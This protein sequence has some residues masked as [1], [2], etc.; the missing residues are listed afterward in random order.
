M[1]PYCRGYRFP[2]Y[3]FISGVFFFKAH[4]FG[5]PG[6]PLCC[7]EGSSEMDPKEF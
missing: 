5:N 4:Y 3:Y 2:F 7:Q 1:L 6:G